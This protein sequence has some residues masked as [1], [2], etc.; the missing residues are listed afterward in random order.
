MCIDDFAIK[1]RHSYGTVMIDIETH[2]VIDLIDSRNLEDVIEWLKTYKN[3]KIISRDGS[4]TYKS[5]IASAH[6]S[7][8]QVSDRFHLLKNLT[9]Y[10]K[11]YL[12]SKFQSNITIKEEVN[13]PLN[14]EIE[15]LELNNKHLT[16]EKKCEQAYQLLAQGVDKSCICKQLDMNIHLFDKLLLLAP[17]ELMEDF[18]NTSE[19]RQ[20]I[21]ANNK[22][23]VVNEARKLYNEKYSMNKISKILDIDIRTVK[24]YIDPL[25]N[26]VCIRHITKK[27]ILDDYKSDITALYQKGNTSKTIY[28]AIALKGYTGSESNLRRYCSQL[29]KSSNNTLLECNEKKSVIIQREKL[30]M[31]LYKPAKSVKGLTTEIIKQVNEK[32]PFFK[33]IIELIHEFKEILSNKKASQLDP[34]IE[35]ATSLNNSYIHSFINGITRDIDAV[36]NAIIYDYNNGLAEGSVNKLKVIK[37]IMYGRNSFEMLKRK[38]LYLEAR[39]LTN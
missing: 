4:L 35:Y 34:W 11:D 20:I 9:D 36:K 6:P 19:S 1:K 38:I 16:L 2:R 7:A 5:A 33:S 32:Y 31:L 21:K 14:S 26:P 23:G 8:I 39:K 24:K 25:F 12:K 28:D 3:L 37:R 10:C 27:S 15:S 17:K 18:K 30:L 13:V 22:M 29:K